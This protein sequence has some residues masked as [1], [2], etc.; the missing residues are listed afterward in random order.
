[1]NIRFVSHFL[2]KWDI[3]SF[4]FEHLI[5]QVYNETINRESQDPG[6]YHHHLYYDSNSLTTRK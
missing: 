4:F 3:S 5:F 6:E 2:Y 1:M